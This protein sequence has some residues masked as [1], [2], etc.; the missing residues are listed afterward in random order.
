MPPRGRAGRRGR[1]VLGPLLTIVA[2]VLL[3]LGALAALWTQ[4]LWYDALGFGRVLTTELLTKGLLFLVGLLLAGGLTFSS[5]A[6]GYRLRPVYAPVTDEQLALDRYRSM[7][8]PLRR[9]AVWVVPAM[10]GIFSGT[11]LASQWQ[12]F[13]LW[14][15]QVPFG[16]TDP[17]FGKDVG[18]FVFTLP[19]VRFVLDF[20]LMAF[21]LAAI[22]AALTHYLYGGLRPPGMA[23]RSTKAAIVHLSSLFAALALLQGLSYWF[24]RYDLALQDSGRITGITY[25]GAHAVLPGKSILAVAAVLCALFF[26]ASIWTGSWR[27]PIVGVSLL[28]V[29]ALVIGTIYP[30]LVQSLKVKP[31]ERTLEQPYI[32][33]NIDATRAAFGLD[34]VKKEVYKAQTSVTSGQLRGDAATVPGIRI[35]DPAVVGQT[36]E[37]LQAVKAFYSFPS[38]LDVDRY[39]IDGKTTDAVVGARELR[40]DDL[41]R[42]WR[43]WVNDHT[44]YTHGFGLVAAYGNKRGPDGQP[45]FFE[46]NI[47]STGKLGPYE[48]RIYFGEESPEYSI[49][50]AP[51]GSGDAELDHPD[52]SAGGQRN[53][54][55]RGTGGV[56]IGSLTRRL[57]YAVAY[58][59]PNIMLS[60]AVNE[61]S[62]LL[63]VRKPRDRIGKVAPWLTLDGDPYPAVVD[64]R[65]LW[66]VDGYTTTANYPYA[67][68]TEIEEVTSD[69]LTNA[70]RSNVTAQAPAKV[71]YVRNSVKATVDAYDGK[72]HLY[73]WDDQDPLLK[74]WT[75]AFPGT[76]EPMSAIT[77]ELMQHLRYPED[78]FKVQRSMLGKYH[79]TDANSFF[80]GQD[81]WR[82]PTDPSNRSQTAPSQPPY[83]LSLAMPG[84][85]DP[86][87]SLTTSFTPE[88]RDVLSAFVAAD[89]D[90]GSADGKRRDG[91]GTLRMLELPRDTQVQG[92]RQVANNIFSSNDSS[93][94]FALTLSQFLN[95]NSQGGSKVSMGNLLTLPMGGGVLYVQPI[96]VQASS[97]SSSSYPQS[98]AIVA[99]FGDKLAWSDTLDG[100]LD[101]LFGGSS[102][103]T[104]GDQGSAPTPP[105]PQQPGQPA[106]APQP[107]A[108]SEVARQLRAAQTAMADADKALAAGD[109]AAYGEAQ[110]RLRSALEAAVK[111]QQPGQ[112]V[113]VPTV[114]PSATP[115]SA[116]PSSPAPGG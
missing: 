81:F 103:A 65:I 85:Q 86:T 36:F 6:L 60:S 10:L 52:G 13:L 35:V 114:S 38:S 77:G 3:A 115:G 110:K 84:Q 44:V 9:L 109:F 1:G 50:G 30:T 24:G 69:A 51:E 101:G 106:P 58:R 99:A 70:S 91:Y 79:V 90:A 80:G 61:Q 17:E 56:A 107:G 18:F 93:P 34:Q 2:V 78:L 15:N 7:L 39:V 27:L 76:V 64:G 48:P 113:V 73:A 74:A 59:E 100:A 45:V 72:V 5:I 68:R 23:G 20:T 105:Q 57:A 41:D 19:W 11:A 16:V 25:T 49:V 97:G 95:N 94:R 26:L 104:A 67:Q 22:V 62:R 75:K 111:A 46:Q 28:A 63:D 116:T 33:R 12:T 87:F 92:P 96:Y 42:S 47:P 66:I 98:K 8:D 54:T 4:V 53:T 89:A 112:T 55:Y 102:G 37:A 29:T 108:G 83:Y 40:L 21:V 43:N 88:N 14:R 71:N 82:V 32:Q 31:S